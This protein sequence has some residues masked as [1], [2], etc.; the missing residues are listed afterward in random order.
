MSIKDFHAAEQTHWPLHFA[1]WHLGHHLR[2]SATQSS[3]LTVS[4]R[5]CR[6]D[7]PRPITISRL[8]DS[9]VTWLYG[10]LHEHADPV[11]PPK[12]ATTQDRLDLDDSIQK[13]S[14]LKHRT[15][16]E[17]LT[18]PG[19]S[20]SPAVEV[21]PSLLEGAET[22]GAHTP[23]T[24]LLPVRSDTHLSAR[25]PKTGGSPPASTRLL[26]HPSLER[27]DTNGSEEKRHISFNQRVDQC[28]AVDYVEDEYG[29]SDNDFEE[30]TSEEDSDA[31]E[32]GDLLTM[33]SSPHPSSASQASTSSRHSSISAD[34]MSTIAKLAPTLLKT[35]D[36]YPAP[37]PAVVDPTGFTSLGESS[38]PR[39]SAQPHYSYGDDD[40]H[41][42]E[43]PKSQWEDDNQFDYFSAPFVS[44]NE[45]EDDGGMITST[46]GAASSRKKASLDYDSNGSTYRSDASS[47][48][49]QST[50]ATSTSSGGSQPPAQPRSIL[51][52]KPPVS[53]ESMNAQDGAYTESGS[54]NSGQ[55]QGAPGKVGAGS[56]FVGG[57]GDADPTSS[58]P[59][60]S[61][62]AVASSYDSADSQDEEESGRGRTPQRLGSSASYERIQEAA[63]RS[64]RS[65]SAG[66]VSPS[67]SL[68]A[69]SPSSLARNSASG[70]FVGSPQSPPERERRGSFRGRDSDGQQRSGAAARLAAGAG[71]AWQTGGEPSA[72]GAS[73]QSVSDDVSESEDTRSSTGS[74]KRSSSGGPGGKARGGSHANSSMSPAGSQRLSVDLDNLPS[75]DPA[76]AGATP[77]SGGQG[78]PTPLNTPTLALARGR[79]SKSRSGSGSGFSIAADADQDDDADDEEADDSYGYSYAPSKRRSRSGADKD[80]SGAPSSPVL[81]RRSS[82]T[83]ALVAPSDADRQAGVRVPLADDYVEGDE[84]GIIGRAVEIVNTARDL[85]AAVWPRSR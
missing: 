36:A 58:S 59:S 16:S 22:P 52:R 2:R 38:G 77:Q 41:G 84:G 79:G 19:R 25:K 40:E 9:D 69:S 20:A 55:D 75:N 37:S 67:S 73:A 83:G 33:K 13:K 28:I 1:L 11:P 78:G 48:S 32:E 68:E 18:T 7:L 5:G 27:S 10:P 12:I 23:K 60:A 54:T 17:M 44:G 81:P 24:V 65:V 82:A 71:A 50:S 80:A 64:G 6:F 47:N 45:P 66:S 8:K 14:I 49:S 34:S 46:P 30:E 70:T 35:S 42:A 21:H 74:S 29:Y 85:I 72:K 15:I 62:S 31:S 57:N 56:V 53:S 63:R 3:L 76:V 4:L 43:Q 39:V 61:T 26:T 51:K